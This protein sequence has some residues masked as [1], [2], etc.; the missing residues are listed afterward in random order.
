M[1]LTEAAGDAELALAI[2][3]ALCTNISMDEHVRFVIN[4]M[5]QVDQ[6]RIEEREDRKSVV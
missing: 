4:N 1:V 3:K 2:L 5:K 6:T